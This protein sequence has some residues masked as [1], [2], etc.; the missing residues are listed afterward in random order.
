MKDVELREFEA[1]RKHMIVESK[2]PRSDDVTTKLEQTL[3]VL[4]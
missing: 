2:V 4:P 3:L 1:R